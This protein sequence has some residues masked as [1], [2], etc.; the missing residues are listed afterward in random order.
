MKLPKLKTGH[1]VAIGL[2]LVGIAYLFDPPHLTPDYYPQ[3]K[4]IIHGA[5]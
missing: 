3:D 2:A 4:V 5:E 1:Y